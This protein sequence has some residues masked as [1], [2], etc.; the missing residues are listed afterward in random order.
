MNSP[1]K[2]LPHLFLSTQVAA[3]ILLVLLLLGSAVLIYDYSE[4]NKQASD[5][6]TLRELDSRISTTIS[7]LKHSKYSNYDKLNDQTNYLRHTSSSFWEQLPSEIADHIGKEKTSFQ[8]QLERRLN[9]I[10]QFKSHLA[11]L[12]NSLLYFSMIAGHILDNKPGKEIANLIH[13]I[14]YKHLAYLTEGDYTYLHQMKQLKE[15]LSSINPKQSVEFEKLLT[16]IEMIFSYSIDVHEMEQQL[17]EESLQQTLIKIE[18]IHSQH[19]RLAQQVSKYQH[20][21][22]PALVS[23]LLVLLTIALINLWRCQRRITDVIPAS[24]ALE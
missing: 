18:G 17:T 19:Y 14:R 6:A 23:L 7:S 4:H 15:K 20:I 16:H 12:K 3:A 5:L 9:V 1:H 24:E 11:V 10:E 13:Q 22:I 8:G 21:V 2:P